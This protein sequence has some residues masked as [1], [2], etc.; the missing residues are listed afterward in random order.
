MTP[1]QYDA[2]V[3]RIQKLQRKALDELDKKYALERAKHRV[4]E[5]VRSVSGDLFKIEDVYAS[6][7]K[8]ISG[9][10]YA[11]YTVLKLSSQLSSYGTQGSRLVVSDSIIANT[12]EQ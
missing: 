6:K 12:V 10:P 3:L 9:R 2:K 11:C 8:D 5:I 1:Q 7:A 4:G